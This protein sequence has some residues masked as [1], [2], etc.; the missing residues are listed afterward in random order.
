MLA[1]RLAPLD[2]ISA[3]KFL[4]GK[5]MLRKI[6]NKE[7]KGKIVE[8]EAYLGEY[9]LASHSFQGETERNRVMFGPAGHAYVYFTYGM[10]YCLNVVTGPK[11]TGEAVL[12]RA[13]EPIAGI[14]HMAKN[15]GISLLSSWNIDT[16]SLTNGPAKL[17]QALQI[18]KSL[19]GHD[20][21][22][23][24]LYLQASKPANVGAIVTTTR[25]G[26]RN[27]ADLPLRFYIKNN[28]FVSKQ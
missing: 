11:D 19:N 18:D 6:G 17:C 21:S 20:L 23:P 9:D 25:I 3:A 10:H 4:L 26:I 13:L 22:Q 16:K 24:P 8:T 7:L 14:N 12:I 2:T 1:K 27:G 28:P 5:I 15:R